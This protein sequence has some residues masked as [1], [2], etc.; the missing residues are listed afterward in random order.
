MK[1]LVFGFIDAASN[2]V[3]VYAYGFSDM[4]SIVL[5]VSLIV[6]FTMLISWIWLK[7]KYNWA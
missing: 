2:G 4:A 6:P 5:I 7:K 3:N 1:P